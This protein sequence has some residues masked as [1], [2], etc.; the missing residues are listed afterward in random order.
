[1]IP[2]DLPKEVERLKKEL[3]DLKKKFEVFLKHTHNGQDSDKINLNNAVGEYSLFKTK[4]NQQG[5]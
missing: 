1:M 3:E 4:P 2:Q 5:L